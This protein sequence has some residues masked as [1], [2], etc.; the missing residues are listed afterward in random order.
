MYHQ[1]F[2]VLHLEW[3]S[4][5]VKSPLVYQVFIPVLHSVTA[6]VTGD[7]SL[8]GDVWLWLEFFL[9]SVFVLSNVVSAI[10]FNDTADLA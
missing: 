1:N 6:Q 5:L 4:I 2:P 7:P 3:W 10:W 8:H 9:T